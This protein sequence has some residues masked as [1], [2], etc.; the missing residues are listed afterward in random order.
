MSLLDDYKAIIF[1]WDGTLVDSTDWVLSAHNYVRQY[2]KQPLWTKDDIFGCS[3]LSTRELYPQIYGE[4]AEEAMGLLFDY[5]DKHNFESARPYDGSHS[6]LE[7]L[8][9]MDIPTAVVSNK[10]HEPLNDVIDHMNWRKFFK[11]AIGAGG[12]ERDK[13]SP[14]PFLKAI[15]GI[16]YMLQPADVIYVGDTETDLLCAKNAG[17]DV[18]FIQSDGERPDL[19]EK[20]APKYQFM[21]IKEFYSYIIDEKAPKTTKTA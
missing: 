17:C 10:R 3:S 13:P 12:A 14:I 9:E 4:K 19:I 6:L 8:D 18:V 16:N 1:D 21:T 11:S 7:K 5:T 2:M 20:Y 15:N